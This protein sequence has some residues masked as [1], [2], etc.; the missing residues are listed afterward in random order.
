VSLGLKHVLTFQGRASRSAFWWFFLFTMIAQAII[1]IV[2][3]GATHNPQN[4]DSA[5]SAISTL[6]TLSVSV[7][8]LHDTN[9]SGWWWLIGLVPIVGWIILLFF[10]IKRGTPGPNRF[11]V[12]AS[13]PYR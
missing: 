1:D 13:T 10:Y 4:I 3:S 6:L 8:R 2:V 12:G 11:D 7:R 5:L 9:R